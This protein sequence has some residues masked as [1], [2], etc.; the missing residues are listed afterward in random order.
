MNILSETQV[1]LNTED[2]G[3]ICVYYELKKWQFLTDSLARGGLFASPCFEV[4][5]VT[6]RLL[7]LNHVDIGRGERAIPVRYR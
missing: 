2:F 7:L 4:D 1:L 6:T 3:R 5:D